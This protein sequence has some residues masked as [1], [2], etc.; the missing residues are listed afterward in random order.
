MKQNG[1]KLIPLTVDGQILLVPTGTGWNELRKEPDIDEMP[2]GSIDRL[3]KELEI[4]AQ[5]DELLIGLD[6]MPF[7]YP[8]WW[9]GYVLLQTSSGIQRILFEWIRC[10]N[11]QWQG[12]IGN[13]TDSTIYIGARNKMEAINKGWEH[14]I[15]PCI[16]CGG[17]LP[18]HP[19]WVEGAK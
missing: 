2:I 8:R 5:Y 19:I 11:C 3:W 14:P 4:V 15:I 7:S 17:S 18:R 9:H 10:E 12:W 13:P 16:K 6:K 1:P